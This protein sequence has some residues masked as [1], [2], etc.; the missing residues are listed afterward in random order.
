LNDSEVNGRRDVDHQSHEATDSVDR[1]TEQ[2]LLSGLIADRAFNTSENRYGRFGAQNTNGETPSDADP[3]R[4]AGTHRA[5]KLR[6]YRANFSGLRYKN[7]G[8]QMSAHASAGAQSSMAV[9]ALFQEGVA[10]FL[11]VRLPRQPVATVAMEP[12]PEKTREAQMRQ[13]V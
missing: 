7:R 4:K 11:P 5:L 9:K 10:D 2:I 3:R 12:Q 8:S 13:Q 1:G 6:L